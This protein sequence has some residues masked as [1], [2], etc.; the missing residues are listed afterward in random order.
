MTT[1]PSRLRKLLTVAPVASLLLLLSAC[2]GQGGPQDTFDPEGPIA[3][4]IMNLVTPVFLVAAVVFVL[5]EVGTV[6]LVLRF[7]RRKDEPED[8]FPPQTHGNMKLEIVWTIAPAV[9]LAV[10]GIAT[11]ATIFDIEA[12][13]DEATMSVTVVGQQWWWEYQ[14]DVDGDDEPD[15]ITANDLVIP[16]DTTVKLEIESRDVIH[17]F[18]IPKL[19]GKK[20]AVPGHVEELTVEADKPDTYVGQCTEYC[21]L[22]HAYMRQ[23]LVALDQ[24]DYDAWVDNQLQPAEEAAEGSA[25]AAG[26]ETFINVCSRCHLARGINDKE[27]EDQGSGD[28]LVSGPA[29]DLTHF[30]TRGAFAGAIFDL[31][32][33]DND[34]GIVQYDEIGG[35]LNKEALEAWLRNPPEEKPMAAADPESSDIGRGM[36][37]LD[38][39]EEQ[40]DQL[41]AW[42]ETLD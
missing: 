32:E 6:L 8:E 42:L 18:W 1:R 12:A 16:A 41:S 34:A 11:V 22:S 39:T 7:R 15:I 14:Y 28:D 3:D 31:W 36:P 26:E 13:A 19:N 9:L 4:K 33:T 29:P 37:D 5:V 35:T 23:R 10:I 40:I 21:G 2:A 17:S 38:L 24:A 25:A 30:A 20:D 27:F